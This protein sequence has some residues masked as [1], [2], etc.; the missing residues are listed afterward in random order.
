MTVD[1]HLRSIAPDLPESP[2]A[3]ALAGLQK[4]A[5]GDLPQDGAELFT[6]LLAKTQDESEGLLAICGA[7][8]VDVVVQGATR[9]QP[10]AEL[11][12]AVG[13]G[14][15]SMVAAY[16]LPAHFL[17]FNLGSGGRFASDEL[18]RLDKLKKEE[19]VSERN[20]W[21]FRLAGIVI[22]P[23]A[24]SEVDQKHDQCRRHRISR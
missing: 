11:T 5:G 15:G 8:T 1:N 19:L 6:V 20:G 4:S 14:H 2:A 18:S 23:D 16:R 7:V 17:G 13:A 9:Q 12:N 3:V 24:F 10:G 22:Q 21:C